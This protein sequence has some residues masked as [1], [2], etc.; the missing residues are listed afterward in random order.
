MQLFLITS[1]HILPFTQFN[2]CLYRQNDKWKASKNPELKEILQ[3]KKTELLLL[4]DGE[5][6]EK[7]EF[8]TEQKMPLFTVINVPPY[9]L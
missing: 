8:L 9:V 6:E 4:S 3:I 2:T 5:R 1:Y 7:K